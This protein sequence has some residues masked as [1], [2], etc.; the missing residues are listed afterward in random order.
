MESFKIDR[1]SYIKEI[2]LKTQNL[3]NIKGQYI[4]ISKIKKQ[5]IANIIKFYNKEKKNFEL[6]KKDITFFFNLLIKNNFKI[7]GLPTKSGCL[8]FDRYKDWKIYHNKKLINNHLFNLNE[9]FQGFK[10]LYRALFSKK[11]IVFFFRK[12]NPQ[13]FILKI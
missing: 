4:G 3:N 1:K 7:K 9:F 5:Q 11:K 6:E 13:K 10:N 8:E 12:I 2:G